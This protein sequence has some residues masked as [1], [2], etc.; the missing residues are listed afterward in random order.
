MDP[1]RYLVD[2]AEVDLDRSG[3]DPRWIWSE[4]GVDLVWI[5]G[6]SGSLL[7][8]SGS[9]SLAVSGKLRRGA[10]NLG[11][12]VRGTPEVRGPV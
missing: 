12:A 7:G 5:C 4:S 2:L 6:E 11:L 10:P 1:C 9:L 8:G 3:V